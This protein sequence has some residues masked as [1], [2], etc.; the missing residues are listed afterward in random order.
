MTPL[1]VVLF[2]AVVAAVIAIICL[3]VLFV[4]ACLKTRRF[5]QVKTQAAAQGAPPEGCG[6]QV[7]HEAPVELYYCSV[8]ADSQHVRCAL[9][10]KRVDV[11]IHDVDI[12][13]F[14]RFENLEPRMLRVSPTG[15]LPALVHNGRCLLDLYLV[16]QYIEEAFEGPTLMPKAPEQRDATLQWMGLASVRPARLQVDANG[17]ANVTLGEAVSC[18]NKPMQEAMQDQSI[19]TIVSG[20]LRH[21]NPLPEFG[22]L[23]DRVF[24]RPS[25]LP[26]PA[27]A[28]MAFR[29]VAENFKRLDAVL[30][31][32]REYL[33]GPFTLADVFICGNF[34]RLELLG[35]LDTILAEDYRHL[36]EYWSRLKRRRSF[37]PSFRPN[38]DAK[39]PRDVDRVLAKFRQEVAERGVLVAYGLAGEEEEEDC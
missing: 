28:R 26:H 21:P 24:W 3:C 33:V 30:A 5:V 6:V 9:A 22:K 35:V 32:G 38:S 39:G 25:T 19:L 12:G 29:C 31:D 17:K 8:F 1:K 36:R 10:E 4:Y 23:M 11:K 18:L 15:E 14:G 37:M 7:P 16:L 34:N 2:A 27:A 13:Y 20:I